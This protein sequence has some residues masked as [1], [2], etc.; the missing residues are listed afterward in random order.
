[1][2]AMGDMTRRSA[3]I[4]DASAELCMASR[5]LIRL[6]DDIIQLSREAIRNA[7]KSLDQRVSHAPVPRLSSGPGD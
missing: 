1:M 2:C 5:V 7:R 6:T 3:G 4:F